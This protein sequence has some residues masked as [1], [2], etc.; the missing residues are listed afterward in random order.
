MTGNLLLVPFRWNASI[1][2]QVDNFWI[3]WLFV[4]KLISKRPF[5]SPFDLPIIIIRTPS[6]R[7]GWCTQDRVV[8]L[9][10]EINSWV[11]AITKPHNNG[12]N[13]GVSSLKFTRSPLTVQ[14][15][16]IPGTPGAPPQVGN[17]SAEWPAALHTIPGAQG[18]FSRRNNVIILC[19]FFRRRR[20]VFG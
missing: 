10:A 4:Y 15:P 9:N 11:C 17:E 6:N 14:D 13:N 3:F 18:L 8:S 2:C 1:F 19:Y 5:K 20:M 16:R 7:Q 12:K